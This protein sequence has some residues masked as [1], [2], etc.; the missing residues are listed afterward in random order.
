[1]FANYGYGPQAVI[2]QAQFNTP[3]TS[4]NN[5]SN[6]PLYSTPSLSISTATNGNAMRMPSQLSP[7]TFQQ[8]S[9]S[10]Q[11]QQSNVNGNAYNGFGGYNMLGMGMPGVNMNLLGGF[12]YANQMSAFGPV[13]FHSSKKKKERDFTNMPPSRILTSDCLPSTSTFPAL[14]VPIH[15]WRSMLPP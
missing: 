2:S 4:V 8:Q 15:L 3:G 7:N 1:V 9:Q 12:P 10:Q 13:R 14:P 5:F 6:G 11:Q